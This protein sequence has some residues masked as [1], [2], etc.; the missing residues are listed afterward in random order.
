MTL[1]L[2]GLRWAEV[3]GLQVRDVDLKNNLLTIQKSL[4]EVNGIFH[5]ATTKTSNT[6]V[7]P[8]SELLAGYLQGW[9]HGKVLDEL[10]FTNTNGNPISVSN[11]RN[12]IYKP[13]IKMAKVPSVT[14]QDLR[15][16]TASIAITMGAS[17]M[18]V[19]TMLGHSNTN[20]TLD[21]YT[22]LFP[23]DLRLG[24]NS[25]NEPI[26]KTDVRR[27]FAEKEN[28]D[29]KLIEINK[30]HITTRANVS[31]PCRDRTDDPQI[32]SSSLQ[33]HSMPELPDLPTSSH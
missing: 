23:E 26:T 14:I 21:T 10:V 3:I 1:G 32:K 25:I 9:C 2:C 4:S 7:I 11:F 13:A 22:H 15:H 33:D 27:Q 6:R 16:T 18:G 28:T 17:V 24:S 29:K 31:G 8:I 5:Q 20:M 19:R 12:R 30:V